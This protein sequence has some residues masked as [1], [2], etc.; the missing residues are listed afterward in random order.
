MED[1]LIVGGGPVGLIAAIGLARRGLEVRIIEAERGVLP[2]PRAMTYHRQVLDGF[3]LLDLFDDMAQAGFLTDGGCYRLHKTGEAFWNQFSF[4]EGLDHPYVLTLAI[5]E[6]TGVVLSHL[7]RYPNIRFD[8]G[9]RFLGLKDRGD[10][11]AV[12]LEDA[13]GLET[14]RTRFVVG[15]DGGRSGVRKAIGQ[16]L[17][18]YTWPDRF[19]ATNMR[20]DFAGHGWHRHSNLVI[21]NQYGAIIAR[22]TRAGQ[23]RVTF[24]E[25]SR[26]PEEGL[27]ERIFDYYR[28]VLPA[29][30]EGAQLDLYSAYSMHQRCVAKMRAGR[31][32]LAGDSAHVTNPTSGFGLV[33]GV[34]DALALIDPLA[35]VIRG[36]ADEAILDEY[37]R[38]R[39][40]V[41]LEITSPISCESKRR[42]FHLTDAEL[43]AERAR[44]LEAQKSGGGWGTGA[45]GYASFRLETPNLLTGRTTAEER[46][47]MYGQGPVEWRDEQVYQ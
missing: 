45:R 38:L 20:F 37:S 34:F 9:V 42:V 40:K 22:L 29:E 8:R 18:G 25:D 21:D 32:V 41:F 24:H 47:R 43:A 16:E 30:G 33:G 1:V 36:E 10:H 6:L 46:L 13:A 35:A 19:V 17:L 11:V 27:K 28:T 5:D 31:V 23:W 4:P 15:A 14:I 39:R 2:T 3:I 26:L 7:P 44:L 12:D